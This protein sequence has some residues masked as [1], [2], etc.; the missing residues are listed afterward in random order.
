MQ[1]KRAFDLVMGRLNH[2]L[3]HTWRTGIHLHLHSFETRE[4]P[5]QA[6]NTEM[7]TH[8]IH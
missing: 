8:I 6:Q 1:D 2:T 5:A 7:V 4:W 3:A